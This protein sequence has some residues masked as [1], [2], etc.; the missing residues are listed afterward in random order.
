[1]ASG[2][3]AAGVVQSPTTYYFTKR[4]PDE[5]ISEKLKRLNILPNQFYAALA[6]FSAPKHGG[7][8]GELPQIFVWGATALPA[9]PPPCTTVSG[10]V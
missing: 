2:T 7:G 9:P 1:L 6:I 3:Q 5:M 10:Y 8:G 4:D